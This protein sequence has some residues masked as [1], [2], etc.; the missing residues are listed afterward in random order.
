LSLYAFGCKLSLVRL[1]DSEFGI[2]RLNDITIGI[3]CVVFCFHISH[4]SFASSWY[5]FCLSVIVLARLYYYYYY[6]SQWPHCLRRRSTITRL[7]RLW[8]R[9]PPGT[10]M[11]VV[12][13]VCCQV[14]VSATDWSLVQRSPT[15]SDA[16][17]CVWF[18]NLRNEETM[19]RVGP[20][21]HREKIIIIIIIVKF[22]DI[23][24]YIHIN[25]S[26]PCIGV[27]LIDAYDCTLF[28]KYF[29][30]SISLSFCLV[31]CCPCTLCCRINCLAYVYPTI[32][33]FTVTLRHY[34][35]CTY[36]MCGI[37]S[38]IMRS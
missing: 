34:S 7:L 21:R 30:H 22:C 9:I 32:N 3:T 15:D 11:S 25:C 36:I 8:F 35:C 1:C 18:R 29:T 28:W 17:L 38:C 6:R 19:A 2:T 12:S 31:E 27:T 4:I 16:S 24:N 26:F 20:Q 23:L 37:M 13:A 5:L 10:W 14:E 33:F